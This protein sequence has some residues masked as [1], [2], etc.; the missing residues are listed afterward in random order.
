MGFSNHFWILDW[1]TSPQNGS[2][3]NSK[4]QNYHVDC[5]LTV[6]N[7]QK[8]K[9]KSYLLIVCNRN[10]NRIGCTR[11]RKSL[12]KPVSSNID[13]DDDNSDEPPPLLCSSPFGLSSCCPSFVHKGSRVLG[14]PESHNNRVSPFPFFGN[15]PPRQLQ[16]CN[17]WRRE[18]KS[19]KEAQAVKIV[20]GWS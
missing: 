17:N 6:I 11:L 16:Q 3:L 20:G 15:Q 4:C 7:W 13:G 19:Q 14:I 8:V 12:L 18:Y 2:K 10:Q 5:W 9:I 1:S